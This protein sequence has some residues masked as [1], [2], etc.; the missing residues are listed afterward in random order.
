ML[1]SL[2][3]RLLVQAPVHFPFSPLELPRS[4]VI[5][6]RGSLPLLHLSKFL[7]L[8]T[9]GPWNLG[10]VPLFFQQALVFRLFPL[11]W[12]KKM[13]LLP[14][15]SPCSWAQDPIFS[16][17]PV[18][19]FIYLTP[20]VLCSIYP[21]WLLTLQSAPLLFSLSGIVPFPRPSIFTESQWTLQSANLSISRSPLA[22]GSLELLKQSPNTADQHLGIFVIWPW[23]KLW[24]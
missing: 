17:P 15:V 1:R 23:L 12:W 20:L 14:P 4:E 22:Q 11:T 3:C 24:K 10:P 8:S 18:N 16:R 19:D 2:Q 6:T 7:S 13:L 21:A 5:S 9:N